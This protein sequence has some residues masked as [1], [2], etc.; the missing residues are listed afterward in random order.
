MW[1]EVTAAFCSHTLPASAPYFGE[2]LVGS[3]EMA[4]E[5]LGGFCWMRVTLTPHLLVPLL[6]G[7]SSGYM[8]SWT[9]GAFIPWRAPA[10]SKT[11]GSA[12][13]PTFSKKTFLALGGENLRDF[14]VPF[15][16]GNN[17]CL[18]PS[19]S[20]DVA[21]MFLRCPKLVVKSLKP[22]VF[23]T[24]MSAL[25]LQPLFIVKGIFW[26]HMWI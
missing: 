5:G 4:A 16:K 17:S 14:Q 26:W 22:L 13:R 25:N 2:H 23:I 11:V 8:G 7:D 19:C 12:T 3:V 10:V 20:K 9:A 15:R 24:V 6:W 18:Y 1:W 21:C